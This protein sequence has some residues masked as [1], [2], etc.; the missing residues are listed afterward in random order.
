MTRTITIPELILTQK[1]RNKYGS[2]KTEY[3]GAMYDSK[4]E[5]QRAAELDVLMKCG[6]IAG[7]ERQVPYVI[8]V[9]GVYVCTYIVD[10]RVTESGVKFWAEDVKGFS[11]PVFRLKEKLFRACYPN[12]DLRI[13]KI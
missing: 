6:E 1:R 7:W 11:T 2:K 3:A 8:V 5:A 12:V 9:N 13:L 4:A 10:F